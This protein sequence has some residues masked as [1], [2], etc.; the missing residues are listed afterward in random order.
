MSL[1]AASVLH[2]QPCACRADTPASRSVRDSQSR[3][4]RSGAA[5]ASI[6]V[7]T[8]AARW[9][10]SQAGSSR[11][12]SAPAEATTHPTLRVQFVISDRY[13]DRGQGEADVALRSVDTD[14]DLVGRKIGD[15]IG[16]PVH[17]V[18]AGLG[19]GPLPLPVGDAEPD[20]V[21]VLE[22]PWPNC[23]ASGAC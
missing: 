3:S 7:P 16:D 19:V 9:R 1:A 22:S 20:L 12:N 23:R 13:I 6:A 14:D 15:S 8:A 2:A 17:S 18:K 10:G 11:R 4:V 21:R 5:F